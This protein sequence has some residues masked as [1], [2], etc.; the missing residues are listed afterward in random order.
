MKVV[1]TYLFTILLIVSVVITV[2]YVLVR[3][4]LSSAEEGA[5]ATTLA[6]VPSTRP[7][8]STTLPTAGTTVTTVPTLPS[9]GTND[10]LA[11]DVDPSEGSTT[12]ST[13][14][15]TT[16]PTTTL[17]QTMEEAFAD[18]LFIGDSRT[19]GFVS[20]KIKVPGATFFTSE[21]MSASGVLKRTIDVPGVGEVTFD[22]LLKQKKFKQVYIMFGLNEINNKHTNET[23]AAH[24]QQII[25]K[26]AEAQ[27]EAKV[28]VQS[29][30][31]IT[32]NKNDANVKSHNRITNARINELNSL[33]KQ[34]VD[35]PYVYYLD[36][37]QG[38]GT[39]DGA[40]NATYSAG[41]GMHVNVRGYT[42]WRDFLFENRI[43]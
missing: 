12:E 14:T 37:N 6:F 1:S 21:G 27:P 7:R 31:H 41:D 24:Y 33:L 22:E 26:I 36:I 34:L 13:T 35:E 18:T 43:L 8:P 3:D 25:A 23:I 28:I 11:T 19:Y 15:T 42:A 2:P 29:T 38:L 30:L 20:Y 4:E 32:K 5:T 17:S 16:V 9:S 40:L 39:D 10:S